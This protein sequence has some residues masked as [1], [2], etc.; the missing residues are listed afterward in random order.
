MI[1]ELMKKGRLIRRSPFRGYLS[2][3]MIHLPPGEYRLQILEDIDSNDRWTPA[4][5][6]ARRQ[7]EK[8]FYYEEPVTLKANWEVECVWRVQTEDVVLPVV[9]PKEKPSA[10]E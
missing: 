2:E 9:S 8:M 6:E 1:F 3:R 10:E 7:A 5:W 4:D